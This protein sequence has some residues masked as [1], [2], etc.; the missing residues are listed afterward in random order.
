[1]LSLASAAELKVERR[2][3]RAPVRAPRPKL[4]PALFPEAVGAAL[5]HGWHSALAFFRHGALYRLTLRG[6]VPDRIVFPPTDPRPKH[7]DDA[8]GFLRN[9]F[10]FDSQTLDAE[11]SSIFDCTLPGAD[12]AAALHGFEWLRHLEAAGGENAKKLSLKLASDWLT[13]HAHYGKPAWRPEI[14]AARFINVFTHGRFFLANSDLLWR[15]KFF[16]SLRNQARVL[17]RTISEAP[18]GVPRFRAAAALVLAGLCLADA[19]NAV[20]GLTR[21]GKEIE[22]QILPDGGHVSRS[23]QALLETFLVLTMV[24]QTLE[25]AHRE[26]PPAIRN[27]L[28][29]M[30]PMLRFFRAGD[31]ALAV[32]NGGAENDARYI[33]ALLAGEDAQGKPFGHAP[34]SSF[35]RLAAGKTIVLQ[36]IGMPPRGGFSTEAHAECL[37]F[38]MSVG[39]HRLIVNCGASDGQDESWT[40]ALRGTAA[41]ST[42]TL[43]DTP[44]AEVLSVSWLESALGPRLLA[45]GHVETRRSET[46]EG[47]FVESSH[48]LYLARY[49]IVHRRR[50]V[51]SPK[52]NTLTGVDRL[53]PMRHGPYRGPALP[54]AIR[55]HVHPDVRLSLAQGGGSV[56][57]KLPSGEGWRF[58][59]GGPLEIE[60]SVYLG[61]GTLRRSEQLV[62]AGGIRG[63]EVE[64]A[65]TLEQT[66]A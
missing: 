66:V 9:R 22:R 51:L 54:F 65:W 62:I 39:G 60:E 5:V 56:I 7:L 49:G 21:L 40:R 10:R 19:R 50:L 6:P 44:S 58:R 28:D 38:E 41:H 63:E 55:F 4:R 3:N 11:H 24:Q 33:G 8:D 13:R 2:A 23:P 45:T 25:A 16:V 43:N 53:I 14:I 26:S 31:G 52:G 18:D 32:F 30:A 1:M 36:D 35:Q 59:Y 61:G 64:C 12:F 29:R 57:L 27:A 17:A 47:I 34:H 15:S 46:V 42:L 20:E 48:D 37:A